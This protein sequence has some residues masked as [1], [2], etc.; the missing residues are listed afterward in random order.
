M[1]D[2][3]LNIRELPHSGILD[4]IKME[5]AFVMDQERKNTLANQ[6]PHPAT[7]HYQCIL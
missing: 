4:M 5:Q 1:L 7:L 3:K 2:L 6:Q